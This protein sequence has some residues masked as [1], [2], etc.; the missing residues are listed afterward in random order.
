MK[1]FE[2]KLEK[3][4]SNTEKGR[5]AIRNE[6]QDVNKRSKRSERMDNTGGNK[7]K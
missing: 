6:E 1:I 5:I 3:T 2:E 7:F 4:G